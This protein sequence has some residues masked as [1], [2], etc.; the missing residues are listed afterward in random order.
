MMLTMFSFSSS[1]QAI[2]NVDQIK[3][4]ENLL[5]EIIETQNLVE[6]KGFILNSDYVFILKQFK[7][8]DI[9]TLRITLMTTKTEKDLWQP[10]TSD[11]E[12]L[13]CLLSQF[14]NVIQN[15]YINTEIITILDKEIST[16][17]YTLNSETGK[18]VLISGNE[19]FSEITLSI[20][21]I[22]FFTNIYD[23]LIR[24]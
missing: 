11:E 19:N 4:N 13:T 10:D 3:T 7:E 2:Y 8:E 21:H 14:S 1:S 12:Y 6:I 16:K 17:N 9:Q 5:C 22:D 18:Y 15:F 23:L 20:D 24:K